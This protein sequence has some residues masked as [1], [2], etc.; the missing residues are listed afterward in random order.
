VPAAILIAAWRWFP[1]ASAVASLV[2]V[3]MLLTTLS[4]LVTTPASALADFQGFLLKDAVLLG[5]ALF[6]ASESLARARACAGE[7]VPV[8]AVR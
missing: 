2:A 7:V 1:R 6:T 8:P 3:G 5:A 4:F